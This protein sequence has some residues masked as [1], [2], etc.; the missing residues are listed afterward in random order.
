MSSPQPVG[1]VPIRREDRWTVNGLMSYQLRVSAELSC[2]STHL[3]G[4]VD[5]LVDTGALFSIVHY[6]DATKLGIGV[7]SLDTLD[8]ARTAGGPL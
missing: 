6:M 3:R 7:E 4:S 5:F 1:K 8:F 2:H